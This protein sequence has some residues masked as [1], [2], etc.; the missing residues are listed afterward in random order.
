MTELALEIVLEMVSHAEVK[1]RRSIECAIPAPKHG[2][3][4]SNAVT[5]N[6]IGIF[7]TILPITF[8]AR[9]DSYAPENVVLMY[10]F[11]FGI[12]EV[13][14]TGVQTPGYS[15]G[16]AS[17]NKPVDHSR[18]W[19]AETIPPETLANYSVLC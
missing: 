8:L 3:S 10:L 19:R 9:R 7:G 17:S 5:K 4:S 13:S 16:T 15:R 6:R 12:L 18:A 2:G 1:S 11:Y 14:L